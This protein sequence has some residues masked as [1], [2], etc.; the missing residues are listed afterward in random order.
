MLTEFGIKGK[1]IRSSV[2]PIVT[3]YEL[4]PEPGIKAQ[5]IINLAT[6]IARSMSVQSTRIAPILDKGVIGIELVN[7]KREMV[8]LSQLIDDPSYTSSQQL[9]LILGCDR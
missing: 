3:L 8:Y 2:G 5:R 6:D 1:I 9:M 7:P 4:E